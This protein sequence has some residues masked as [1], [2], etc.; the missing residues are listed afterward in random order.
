MVARNNITVTLW[1]ALGDALV[2]PAGLLTPAPDLYN[3]LHLII[4]SL[5]PSWV[6]A[7]ARLVESARRNGK[8]ARAQPWGQHLITYFKQDCF[9]T[10]PLVVGREPAVS[11]CGP[12][13]PRG[14]VCS[15]RPCSHSERLQVQT[16]PTS[17]NERPPEAQLLKTRMKAKENLGSQGAFTQREYWGHLNV[18]P[19]HPQKPFLPLRQSSLFALKLQHGLVGGA[20]RKPRASIGKLLLEKVR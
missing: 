1:K 18:P 11:L 17:P 19:P 5:V 4:S 14:C 15:L 6:I 2:N 3:K 20:F 10:V 16:H 13:I 7:N 9:V 12:F 8:L